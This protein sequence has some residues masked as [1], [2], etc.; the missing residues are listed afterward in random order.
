MAAG[1][2]YG[3]PLVAQQSL[4]VHAREPRARGDPV[5]IMSGT[6]DHKIIRSHCSHI[7]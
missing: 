7:T 2:T 3:A 6:H 1:V 4:F 5:R